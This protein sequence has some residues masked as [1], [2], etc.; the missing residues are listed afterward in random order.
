[1]PEQECVDG[2]EQNVAR[3]RLLARAGHVVQHPANLQGAEVG[4]QRE[5]G[6]GAK[7]V[8][9]AG[10]RQ[11]GNV[12]GYSRILPHQG[13]VQRLAGVAIPEH[14]GFPL[15]GDA[16]GRQVA[17]PQGALPHGG[18]HH[19]FGAAPDLVGVVLHPP[20]PRVDLLVLFLRAGDDSPGAVE[21][22]EPRAGGALIDCSDVVW[23]GLTSSMPRR[24]RRLKRG[25]RLPSAAAEPRARRR[26][27]R[28]LTGGGLHGHGVTVG[29]GSDTGLRWQ[30]TGR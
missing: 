25:K 21:Y 28:I 16:D 4:R 10:A 3:F 12:F 22:H 8:G 23:H 1:M 26:C 18:R 13:I 11:L 17:G 29:T 20:R 19:L 24:V 30:R 2:A 14:R 6:L 27:Q 15:V 5:A 7:A 9:A